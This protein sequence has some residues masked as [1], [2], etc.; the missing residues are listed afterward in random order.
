[1]SPMYQ[2]FLFQAELARMQAARL[3][4][5]ASE[6]EALVK[7]AAIFLEKVSEE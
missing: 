5:V 3:K 7:S 6:L 4:R 2:S 1:M